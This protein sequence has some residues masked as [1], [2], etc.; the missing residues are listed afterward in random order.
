MSQPITANPLLFLTCTVPV[1]TTATSLLSLINT[2]MAASRAKDSLNYATSCRSIQYTA[3]K[4]NTGNVYV[5]DYKV[6]SGAVPALQTGA[7]LAAGE[8][9]YEQSYRDDDSVNLGS[10]FAVADASTQYLNLRIRY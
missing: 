7:E 6:A 9:A 1:T 8:G 4:S 5:G 3:V 10:L 2:Y